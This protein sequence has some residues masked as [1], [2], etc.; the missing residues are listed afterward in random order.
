[1]NAW[2]IQLVC[3][4][5]SPNLLPDTFGREERMG[6]RHFV[7]RF[8]DRATSIGGCIERVSLA[9][10]QPERNHVDLCMEVLA[11]DDGWFVLLDQQNRCATCGI[12]QFQVATGR[13][14]V[15]ARMIPA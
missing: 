13:V 6:E 9:D 2:S 11:G 12:P 5:C 4:R 14:I 1:M 8:G 3:P 10:W 7:A 15:E